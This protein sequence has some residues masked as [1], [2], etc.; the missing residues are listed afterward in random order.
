MIERPIRPVPT[1]L[2]WISTLATLGLLV[3]VGACEPGDSET[4]GVEI[5]TSFEGAGLGSWE[6]V[7]PGEIELVLHRD[8]GTDFM[9]WY[10]FRVGGAVGEELTFRIVNAGES[11]ASGAWGYNQ[12]VVSSDDGQRWERIAD[13]DYADGVFTFRYTPRTESDWIAYV[14]VYNHSRWLELVER[15]SEHPRLAE[16]RV[17]GE[18]LDGHPIQLLRVTEPSAAHETRPA[19]WAVARQHPAETGGSWKMEGLLEWLLSDDPAA[20]GL[21]ERGEV[22]LVGF[23]NPDGVRMGNYR[24]N[25]AGVNLN[26]VWDHPDPGTE[27]EVYAVHSE[28]VAFARDGGEITFFVDLHSHST[29]RANF[30][31]WNDA[32]AT[33]SEMAAEMQTFMER[34]EV[35]NP[36]FSVEDSPGGSTENA[37]VAGNWAFNAL[38]VHAVTFETAYQDVTYGPYQ[39]EHLTMERL[40][41][42]GRD[43]GRTAAQVLYGVEVGEGVGAGVGR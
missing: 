43:F 35:L 14:P 24:A 15:V 23:L 22:H 31:Y 10:S 12:P 33:S 29:I 7:V 16:V 25:Q 36:D 17:I 37:G 20:A 21:L 40:L 39:G 42:L 4:R 9:R 41:A 38:G 5:D 11:S 2:R 34:F 26:R 13:T 18:S 30:F 6:E 19:L 1:F 3:A 32:E 27:P 8:P 28:M